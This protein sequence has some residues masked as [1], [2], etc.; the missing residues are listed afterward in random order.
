[1]SLGG[2]LKSLMKGFWGTLCVLACA[3]S[4]CAEDAKDVYL[5]VDKLSNELVVR[6]LKNPG[7]V[8][9]K[10]RSITGSNAGDKVSEG[11]R[12]TPEGIYFLE[13][14]IPR[15][16]LRALHGVAAFELNYPNPYD[17]IRKRTG[18]GIWIH[19]VD[20]EERMQK[21]FDTQ[22]CVAL[23]NQDVVELRN[24]IGDGKMTPVIILNDATEE[25]TALEPAG[26][27]LEKRVGE[28][29]KAWGSRDAEVYL[30]FYHPD[31]FARHMNFAGWSAYKR[32]LAKN[33]SSIDVKIRDLRIFRHDKYS[34]ALFW[35]DYRSNRFESA[36]WKRLYWLDDSTAGGLKILSE[37]MRN[38]VSSLTNDLPSVA[39]EG[40]PRTTAS[41]AP[42]A[43]SASESS[44]N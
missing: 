2:K 20:K 31:F 6:S 43:D 30:S 27:A 14:E 33:Y 34:V 38:E 36:G 19:G 44:G 13:R 9:K 7:T 32:R 29:V 24:W 8:L 21:R 26:S 17:R 15:S 39:Q 4:V 23:S 42:E 22:G 1:M 37:E 12:R 28:W 10:F 25:T 35:Q 5:V 40:N 3:S 18:Y 41:T 16:R 11:D